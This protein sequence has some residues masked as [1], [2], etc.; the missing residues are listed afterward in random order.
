[1]TGY[2]ASTN[3]VHTTTVT[4]RNQFFNNS[5]TGKGLLD[6]AATLPIVPTLNTILA[7]GLTGLITTA[8]LIPGGT[9]D[10]EGCIILPP[11][12]FC[13]IYTSTASGV[14]AGAFS[15]QWEEVPV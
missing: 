9:T 8:V 12:A 7:S 3:V 6:S 11:G 4:P 5:S 14:A 15:F 13:A 1:M 10:M 2:H